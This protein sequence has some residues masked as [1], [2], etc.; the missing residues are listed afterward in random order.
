MSVQIGVNMNYRVQYSSIVHCVSDTH[1]SDIYEPT[2]IPTSTK[3][4][5]P[6]NLER[7]VMDHKHKMAAAAAASDRNSPVS[8]C[9]KPAEAAN[10]SLQ[11]VAKA[12]P[13]T[14][15]PPTLMHSG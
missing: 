9:S 3:Q 7:Q 6:P 10:P 12:A 2:P 5:Q 4:S 8:M 14:T 13:E 11:S 15:V 1:R